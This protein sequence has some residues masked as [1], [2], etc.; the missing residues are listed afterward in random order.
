MPASA[1]QLLRELLAGLIEKES[2]LLRWQ[3]PVDDN[4]QLPNWMPTPEILDE[5]WDQSFNDRERWFRQRLAIDGHGRHRIE[6]PRTGARLQ[7]SASFDLLK[8]ATKS[9]VNRDTRIESLSARI[10][11]NRPRPE[12]NWPM[13]LRVL[14]TPGVDRAALNAFRKA[15]LANRG[16][17]AD[18]VRVLSDGDDDRADFTLVFA[19]TGAAGDTFLGN[20]EGQVDADC[21]IVA[22]PMSQK[23][24]APARPASV[25]KMMRRLKATGLVSQS[26]MHVGDGAAVSWVI[27]FVR[28]LS[29]TVTVDVAAM[30]AAER[31]KLSAPTMWLGKALLEHA[32][33]SRRRAMLLSQLKQVIP[34]EV[35]RGIPGSALQALGVDASVNARGLARA[36]RTR[37]T[38]FDFDRESNGAS[39]IAALALVVARIPIRPVATRPPTRDLGSAHLDVLFDAAAPEL[40]E[41]T[42]PSALRFLQAQ[43]L[44]VEG[45]RLVERFDAL[46]HRGACFVRVRIGD[47]DGAWPGFGEE[48]FR[49]ELLPPPDLDGWTLQVYVF[50]NSGEQA[51]N[52]SL[53]LPVA[54]N[55]EPIEFKCVV[56]DGSAP[57]KARVVVAHAN[58][59]LQSAWLEAPVQARNGDV[60]GA[61]SRG[62]EMVIKQDLTGLDERWK[63][64]AFLVV[65]DSL[66]NGPGVA[67]AS[68]PSAVLRTPP[69]LAK[70]INFIDGELS[71]V[72]EKPEHYEGGLESKAVVRLLR[73]LAQYGR[74][75]FEAIVQD[76]EVDRAL[77][78]AERVQVVAAESWARLPIEFFYDQPAPGASAPLCPGAA[79]CL[80]GSM[81][82]APAPCN[83]A[84]PAA[85]PD[86]KVVCPRGFWGL[87]KVIEWHRHSGDKVQV[88]DF[89]LQS[90][91]DTHRKS[92]K[93]FQSILFA[94]SDRMDAHSAQ[95]SADVLAALK[96]ASSHTYTASDWDLWRTGISSHSPLLMVML[97]HNEE[98]P[99]ELPELSIGP[100]TLAT[101]RLLLSSIDDRVIKG[102]KTMPGAIVLL[103]G[104]ETG[105]PKTSYLGYV[106]KFRRYGASII[107]STGAVVLGRQISP[108][109]VRLIKGLQAAVASGPAPL[110]QVML[111]LRREMLANGFPIV[112]AL[113]ASGDAD[114]LI[115]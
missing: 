56:G 39:V 34:S 53:F 86:E 100:G 28:A 12:W 55:S 69:D 51:Q 47:E 113:S 24:V 58:R 63:F 49:T 15:I 46:A 16:W 77:I 60:R 78:D 27:E 108:I 91:P 22:T 33:V 23:D 38:P 104:C 67:I 30:R 35:V 43:L 11:V 73:S 54:G 21:L 31:A 65:N 92:I 29:H 18:H 5:I 45:N 13:K 83:D 25:T 59:V 114:W 79:K 81:A 97:P 74:E 17:M 44:R 105:A 68:G 61:F 3:M 72:S 102:P 26:G 106:P 14:A 101:H 64:D 52:A 7:L 95:A 107:V 84:C 75:M 70:T 103:L 10:S 20:S 57:F 37:L 110:G 32:H 2:P 82:A 99:N 41:L 109:C 9:L 48:P 115:E 96:G 94:H 111:R 71:E 98:S 8:D 62:L 89:R 19:E 4:G 112:L 85:G 76:H 66:T 6:P 88:G 80:G 87:R 40:G 50:A 42:S 36:L 90:E 1:A 93:A